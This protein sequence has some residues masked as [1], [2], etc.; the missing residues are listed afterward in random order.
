MTTQLLQWAWFAGDHVQPVGDV[1]VG[2]DVGRYVGHVATRSGVGPD[3][4]QHR[5]QV[6]VAI[7]ESDTE[8]RVA[9]TSGALPQ[10]TSTAVV[11]QQSPYHLQLHSISTDL[12]NVTVQRFNKRH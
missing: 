3:V 10:T 4:S 1:V 7:S 2:Q 8:Q 11:L 9:L 12:L 5:Q 6:G